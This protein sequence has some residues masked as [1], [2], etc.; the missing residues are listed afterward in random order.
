[1]RHATALVDRLHAWYSKQPERFAV[2]AFTRS[3]YALHFYDSIVVAEKRPI[4]EPRVMMTGEPSFPDPHVEA[5]R[6]RR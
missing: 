4:E 1:V 3:T 5:L 6:V 2:D